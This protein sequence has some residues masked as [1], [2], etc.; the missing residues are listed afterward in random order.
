MNAAD[1]AKAGGHPYSF[2][3]WSWNSKVSSALGPFEVELRTG[4]ACPPPDAPMLKAAASLVSTL[5]RLEGEVV[6]IVLGHYRWH[7]SEASDW[8][9]QEGVP[10]NLDKTRIGEFIRDRALVVTR[11][12]NDGT[13]DELCIYVTPIWDTEHSLSLVVKNG[14]IATVNDTEVK[15]EGGILQSF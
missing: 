8:L 9:T 1:F 3:W 5:Q 15:L 12:A 14:R 2:Y 4:P 13:P 7:Q 10:L 6:D 11:D